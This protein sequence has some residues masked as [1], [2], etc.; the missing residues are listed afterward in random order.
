V[1]TFDP[2]AMEEAKKVLPELVYGEDAYD[3]PRGAM[4]WSWRQ[5]GINF[6]DWTFNASRAC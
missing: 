3:V 2:A 6:D 1:K 4:H 5:S